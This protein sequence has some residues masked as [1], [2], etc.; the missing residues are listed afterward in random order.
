MLTEDIT[1]SVKHDK[2]GNND[3]LNRDAPRTGVITS[4][5]SFHEGFHPL[6]NGK[7]F[8]GTEPMRSSA[9]VE[10]SEPITPRICV[11]VCHYAVAFDIDV[12]LNFCLL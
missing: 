5:S 2:Q 7:L 4:D 10:D 1:G 9:L 3:E 12:T 6:S 8:I 11:L